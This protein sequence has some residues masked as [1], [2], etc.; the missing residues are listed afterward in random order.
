MAPD[1]WDFEV[2]VPVTGPVTP[3]GRVVAGE[4]PGG[5]VART[6]YHG[7]YGGLGGGWEAFAAW[8][9][10]SGHAPAGPFWEVYAA[11][12]ESSQDPAAWRT[13]LYRPLA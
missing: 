6:V 13:E 10:A 12:P 3:S 8:I 5:R 4:F 11:G 7:G 9:A 1:V 2:G